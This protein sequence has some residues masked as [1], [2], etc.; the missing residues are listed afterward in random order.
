MNTRLILIAL[1]TVSISS[2]STAYKSG[3]TPDDVYY[4]PTRMVEEDTRQDDR[5]ASQQVENPEDREIRQG[6]R[7]YRWRVLNYDYSYN[8]NRYNTYCNCYCNK[9]GY[10]YYTH[11]YY[12]PSPYYIPS[13]YYVPPVKVN[14]TPRMVNLA[15]YGGG[16]TPGTIGSINPK[17][18]QP[19]LYTPPKQYNN[20]NND[21]RRGG[22]T[23][24]IRQVLTP[25]SGNNN[26]NSNSSNNTRTY[27][28]S[29]NSNSSSSSSSSSSSGSGGGITRPARGG[30]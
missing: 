16:T 6:I 19:G 24:A 1:A 22:L 12:T 23:N 25:S 27:Q 7:D 5:Q 13:P 15:T 17:N 4:S 10:G 20:S 21:N 2:C 9:Y 30:K 3:Q 28:P 26:S 29:S 8:Y 18:N 11:P 14:T